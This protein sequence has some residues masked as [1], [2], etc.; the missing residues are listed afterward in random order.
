LG[1]LPV[2]PKKLKILS[3][4]YNKLTMLPV[5]NENLLSLHCS[6]NMLKS[7]PVLNEQLISLGYIDNPIFDIIYNSDFKILN[8]RI[9]IW[10]NCRHLYYCLQYEERFR[11]LME[12]I[13]KKKYHPSYLDKFKDDDNYDLDDILKN[14]K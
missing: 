11:K 8:D 2:L 6:R 13:I 9:K 3:C 7:L 1:S 5:L 12:P 10:N 4:C 14:W